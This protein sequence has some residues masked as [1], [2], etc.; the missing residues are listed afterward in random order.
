MALSRRKTI[1]SLKEMRFQIITEPY[2]LQTLFHLYSALA[3]AKPGFQI[4]IVRRLL[5]LSLI[6]EGPDRARRRY[7]R[8]RAQLPQRRMI[9]RFLD[10]WSSLPSSHPR[11]ANLV[12][13]NDRFQLHFAKAMRLLGPEATR[14]KWPRVSFTN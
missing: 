7:N 6:K 2:E 12:L 1:E 11:Y 10:E 5:S 4:S 9:I 3:D 13:P 14:G 8:I